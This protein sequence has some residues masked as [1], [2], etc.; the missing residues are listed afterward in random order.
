MTGKIFKALSM[1]LRQSWISRKRIFNTNWILLDA[2]GIS[3]EEEAD[4]DAGA[5]FPFMTAACVL[6]G[7]LVLAAAGLVIYN[8]LKISITTRTKDMEHFA[9]SAERG[10]IYRLVSLQLLLLCG[11][12]YPI[13]MVLGTL[14]AKG[15]LLAAAD[16]LNPD[17]FLVNSASE[18][19][20]AI[21]AASS[22]KLP[23]LLAG[24]A[25]TL[26][27]ALLA[28]FP[29]ARYASRVSPTVAMSGHFAKIKR[30]G[31]RNRK[32]CHFEAFFA[33]LN[34]NAAGA[35]RLLRFFLLS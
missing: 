18:L 12:G 25:V 29:A 32:I 23:M 1:I 16:H 24:G 8:I 14:S 5:G 34:L 15:L 22:V 31:K 19:T 27:F 13:G 20:E 2:M 28:A 4:G 10:Q 30:R 3:Y 7:V 21:S 6:V 26:L 35:E 11:I 17:I 9:P 33:R